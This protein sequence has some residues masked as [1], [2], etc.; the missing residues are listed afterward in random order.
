MSG[1]TTDLERMTWILPAGIACNIAALALDAW[2]WF[3]W[4][5]RTHGPAMVA[6]VIVASN[7]LLGAIV[8]VEVVRRRRGWTSLI[9]WVLLVLCAVSSYFTWE[10]WRRAA[11]AAWV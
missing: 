2:V 1:G 11:L 6:A 10:A 9:F 4:L 3:A 7:C 8:C 5:G